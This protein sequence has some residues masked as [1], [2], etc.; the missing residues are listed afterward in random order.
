LAKKCDLD[1]F[2]SEISFYFAVRQNT[3]FAWMSW[4]KPENF[5]VGKNAD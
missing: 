3:G 2:F 5:N 1:E 4:E